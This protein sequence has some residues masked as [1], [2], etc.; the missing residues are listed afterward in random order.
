MAWPQPHVG[1]RTATILPS[2]FVPKDTAKYIFS[3]WMVLCARPLVTLPGADN[4]G[5]NWSRD[6]KW[7]YFYSDRGGGP[8]QLWKIQLNGGL[9]VQVT[10]NGGVFGAESEDGRFLYYSKLGVPGIWK[11]PLHGRGRNPGFGS[12]LQGFHHLIR[13]GLHR[14]VGLGSG[15]ER[16]L[17]PQFRVLLQRNHRIFRFF[18]TEDHSHLDSNEATRLRTVN[19]CRWQVHFVCSKRNPENQHHAGEKLPLRSSNPR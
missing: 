18:H 19:I 4:G 10:K 6:G 3:R 11:M 17:L 8:F 12:T 1:R 13:R 16:N 15:S 5:P 7:I 14:L 9:P 2:S